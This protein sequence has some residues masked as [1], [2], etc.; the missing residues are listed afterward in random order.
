MKFLLTEEL[1][2]L[3]RWLRLMGYD[4]EVQA[5]EPRT[6]LYRRAYEEERAVLTRTRSIGASCLFRVVHVESPVLE[7]QL[8][9]VVRALALSPET[10]RRF[11]RCD[12]CNVE[13]QS[14]DKADV[15]GRVPTFVYQTQG[16]F[17]TCPACRRVYWRATHCRR[18]ASVLD[19]LRG[20]DAPEGR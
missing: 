10:E 17:T 8:A 3:A 19:D 11:S 6:A 15:R 16:A 12:R 1:G 2:R 7:A 14:I 5:V 13:L 20:P 4:A 18:A 9:E